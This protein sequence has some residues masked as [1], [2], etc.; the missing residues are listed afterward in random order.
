MCLAVKFH[1]IY[2]S[3]NENLISSGESSF[4][5]LSPPP[6]KKKTKQNYIQLESLP[7]LAG[8]A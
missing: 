3:E 8:I 4:F 2:C 6:L 5:P 7:N 1:S